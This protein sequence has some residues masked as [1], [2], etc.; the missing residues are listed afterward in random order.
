MTR[1]HAFTDDA[2]G[3]HDAVGL[4]A[5]LQAGEVSIPEVV[6][7]AIA[8]TEA[9]NPQ[10][11]AVALRSFDR[12]R[13]QA[14]NPRG[15]FFA[16]VP[17]FIKDNADVA[18]LPTMDGADAWTPRPAAVDGDLAR[19]YLD[20]GV[21]PLGKTQLSEYGFSASAEHP[22]LGPVRSPWD[23]TRTAGASSAGSAA[24]VAAGAVPLAHAND[25]GGSI[26]IPAAVN[27]LV[28]LKGSRGRIPTDVL[29]LGAPIKVVCD[30]VVTRTVRDTAHYFAEAEKIYRAPSLPPIGL[31]EAP[32]KAKLRVA[33]VTDSMTGAIDPVVIDRVRACGALLE[34][35]GHHVEE[36]SVTA[37]PSL[38][39]PTFGQ[40]FPL[41]WSVIALAL[42]EGG[43]KQWGPSYDKTKLDHL[44]RGLA[45]NAKRN[46]HRLPGMLRRL[47]R[48]TASAAEF[49]TRYDV[50][51]SATLGTPTPRLGV[52]DP[53]Q[54]YETVMDNLMK[55]VT[56][57][58]LNNV[59]GTPS[60]SLP[61]ASDTEGAPLGM[62]FSAG[63]GQ[64]RTLLELAFACEEA[65]E[66]ARLDTV[67]A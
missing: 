26:R 56:Y 10:L 63:L 19:M 1:V 64:E 33:M 53:T 35:M 17:T 47:Q 24:L 36:V 22:R 16:G 48:L 9:V 41:Y 43:R 42:V 62:M 31:V 46:A 38:A 58:P 8:R 37:E 30:G 13:S 61:L 49:H 2:L 23:L 29:N 51:F 3:T 57:T 67:S 20:M 34:S 55:W 45:R 7:A 21:I 59:N 5:V 14:G 40:D 15:G 52:L 54:P 44:T 6:E 18:G 39:P 25:G 65:V 28:G 27:G 11:N 12:A 66:F 60:L 32:G 4:A 50:L